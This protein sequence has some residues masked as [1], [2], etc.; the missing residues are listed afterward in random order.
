MKTYLSWCVEILLNV[1]SVLAAIVNIRVKNV[2]M[3]K[4]NV[5]KARRRRKQASAYNHRL[6][7]KIFKSKVAAGRPFSI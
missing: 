5:N 1:W 2:L 3:V 4:T 7:V 6:K